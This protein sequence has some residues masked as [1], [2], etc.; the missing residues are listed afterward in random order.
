MSSPSRVA[1]LLIS[2]GVLATLS[3]MYALSEPEQLVIE[4]FPRADLVQ[5]RQIDAA[6][7][8]VVLGNIRRINNQLRAESEVRAVG[9]LLRMTWRIPE[10]HSAEDAFEHAKEQL[11]QR[12]HTMLYFC[13]ARDCGSSSL[14]ANQVF[15]YSR[16]YGPEENQA[17]LTVRLDGDPQRFVSLYAITRGNRRSYLHVDQFTPAEP[18]AS[19]LY[20]TPATLLKILRNDRQLQ[21]PSLNLS[22][23]EDPDADT[24]MQLLNRMLTLDSR[25]RVVLQG[26]Q[27]GAAAQVLR[28]LGL[29]GQRIEIGEGREPGLTVQAI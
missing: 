29:R 23:T 25:L 19:A 28:D 15:E 3:P 7:H 24:W 20:P 4:P 5:Q 13:E 18:V 12:P 26:Q 10:G 16:L 22:G 17:Y 1:R 9:D 27:A 2:L 11:L 14:W 21:F 6:D 8:G